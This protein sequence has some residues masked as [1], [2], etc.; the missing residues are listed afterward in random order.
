MIIGNRYFIDDL[1]TGFYEVT[2]E[3]YEEYNK[4]IIEFMEAF[5]PKLDSSYK[6]KIIIYGTSGDSGCEELKN[7]FNNPEKYKLKK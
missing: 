7:L 2:K 4:R 1:E 6:G 3:Y 5:R